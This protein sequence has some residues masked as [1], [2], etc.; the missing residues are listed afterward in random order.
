MTRKQ[1]IVAIALTLTAGSSFHA[2]AADADGAKTRAQVIAEIAPA[3]ADGS[4]YAGGDGTPRGL[5]RA[6]LAERE[7]RERQARIANEAR[8]AGTPSRSGS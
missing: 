6:R 1:L 2:L 3:R 8:A 4:F 7:A 5:A